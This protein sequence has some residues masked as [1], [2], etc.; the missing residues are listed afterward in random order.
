MTD[1][2]LSPQNEAH[3][4]THGAIFSPGTTRELINFSTHSGDTERFHHDWSA[5]TAYVQRLGLDGLELLLGYEAPPVLPPGLVQAVHLPFWLTWFDIW[6]GRPAIVAG[7]D[8]FIRWTYGG[9]TA[10]ELIAG[11]QQV[12]QHAARLDPAYMV[13]HVSHIEP[14]HTF[15]RAFSYTSAE[16]CQATAELLNAVV[17]TFP[18]GEPP[19]R[20]ALENLWW[21]GL[22][23]IDNTAEQLAEQL[24][25]DNWAF[26]LDTGH[27]LNTCPTLTDEAQAIGYVLATIERLPTDI[28]ARIECVHLN[29]S[30]SGHYQQAALLEGLPA[31]FAAMDTPA[32]YHCARLHAAQIDQHVAFSSPRCGDILAAL[33]PRFVTH[34]FLSRD[35]AEFDAKLTMQRAAL[36]AWHVRTLAY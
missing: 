24:H 25:F 5:V 14:A 15:T 7:S 16:V 30:L 17:A 19:A 23:F 8:E 29:L 4:S 11:Q 31:G 27:L 22:T 36:R 3:I 20:L 9:R 2:R 12:W 21:P 1:A 26:V 34:E 28:R 10:D 6:R 35:Q 18:H 13:F 33:K 32:Q